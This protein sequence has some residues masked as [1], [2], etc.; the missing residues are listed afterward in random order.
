MTTHFL[1]ILAIL[2]CPELADG[3]DSPAERIG[4][5]FE[6]SNHAADGVIDGHA[7]G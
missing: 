4:W 1:Q 5:C 3:G 7:S 6:S 2:R